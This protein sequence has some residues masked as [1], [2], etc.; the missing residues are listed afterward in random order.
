MAFLHQLRL[1][2]P[3]FCTNRSKI[4]SQGIVWE[5]DLAVVDPE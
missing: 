1:Q 2:T 3:S 4:L 5:I